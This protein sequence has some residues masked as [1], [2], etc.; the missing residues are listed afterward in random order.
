MNISQKQFLPI[1]M[2]NMLKI[3]A[4]LTMTIDHIAVALGHILPDT[5]V[6][7]MRIIGRIAAPLFMYC[8]V[9]GIRY[10]SNRKKYFIRLYAANLIIAFVWSP[11]SYTH[12]APQ[13]IALYLYVFAYVILI[14]KIICNIKE[15]KGLSALKNS[16]IVVLITILPVILDRTVCEYLCSVAFEMGGYELSSALR[17]IFRAI[18]PNIWTVD[19]TLLFVLMGV[20]WY[21]CKNKYIIGG[22]LVIFSAISYIGTYKLAAS[23]F[24]DFFSANQYY[25]VLA[26]PIIMLHND[27]KQHKKSAFSK[28]FFYFYYPMHYMILT[29]ISN[30]IR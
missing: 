30:H 13:I 23:G 29:A 2:T 4:L 18:L 10:T 20:I 27:K 8:L 5:V 22:I 25:M 17:T 26:A 7:F 28:Y 3:I 14:E 19:Y 16:L 15:K 21:F 11:F 1:K 9:N 24:I 6:V 12:S